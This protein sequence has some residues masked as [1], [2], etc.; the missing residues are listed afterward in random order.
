[1]LN[2]TII[3]F[4]NK[5]DFRNRIASLWQAQRDDEIYEFVWPD[6]ETEEEFDKLIRLFTDCD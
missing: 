6:K 3:T 5:T 1:M 2:K 4:K